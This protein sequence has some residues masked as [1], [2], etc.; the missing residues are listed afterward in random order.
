MILQLSP[1]QLEA[2]ESLV[3]GILKNQSV[4]SHA[5]HHDFK[6]LLKCPKIGTSGTIKTRQLNSYD[7]F[8]FNY[9]T[10]ILRLYKV[11]AVYYYR[12]KINKKLYRISLRTKNLK[13]AL[14]R[15]KLFNIMNEDNFMYTIK[16]GEYEYIFEYDTEEEFKRRYEDTLKL[17]KELVEV[18]AGISAQQQEEEIKQKVEEALRTYRNVNKELENLSKNPTLVWSALGAKFI[19]KQRELDK[20]SQS[21]YKAWASVFRK[22]QIYFAEISL[23]TIT[24]EDYEEFR[25]HLAGEYDL[26]NK[27]INNIMKYVNKFLKFAVDRKLLKDNVLEG[28]EH[29]KEEKAI[30]ENYT[31]K[32]VFD[33]INYENYENEEYIKMFRIAAYTGMRVSEICNIGIYN[34]IEKEEGIH[35]IDIKESKTKNG[36][37]KVPIHDEIRDIMLNTTF[38]LLAD[39]PSLSA[40]EKRILRQLYKIVDKN[41][42]KSFHTFRGKFISKG[43]EVAPEKLL[44]IQEIVGHSKTKTAELT[45]NDYGK[46]FSLE[47]KKEIVDAI[48]Y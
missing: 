19:Q 16:T 1:T 6:N 5:V 20:V 29:L 17:H 43:L 47:L 46:G 27:T 2:L 21:T 7:T 26:V 48:S 28:I 33:I 38:P 42:T 30:K 40:K 44:I 13:T 11:G 37:R 24:L 8:N 3:L 15:R 9:D 14:Y 4:E 36:I 41:S 22:L 12:R 34:T 31:D 18:N 23:N 25:I 45:I 35:Y 32:E 39:A 10:S